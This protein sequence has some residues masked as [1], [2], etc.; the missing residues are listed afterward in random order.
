MAIR[1]EYGQVADYAALGVMAGEATAA[2]EAVARQEARDRQVMAIEAQAATQAR[3]QAH[4]KEMAEFGVYMDNIRYQSAEAWELEKMELRSRHDFDMV[5]A[6]REMDFTN[7]MQREQRQQQEQDAKLKAIDET[8][9][10][11]V[12]EKKAA[13][14]KI[15]T[16][17]SLPR[18]EKVSPLESFL[19]EPTRTGRQITPPIK[20]EIAQTRESQTEVMSNFLRTSMPRLD[21]AS[22][23]Q[24]KDIIA[25]GNPTEIKAAYDKIRETV[26][27]ETIRAE[28][29]QRVPPYREYQWRGLGKGLRY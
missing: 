28:Q 5:E 25:R 19:R 29:A 11:S 21:E 4:Q 26:A 18:A 1:V 17:A 8:D 16:G 9:W 13:K 10:L 14:F 15:M 27:P 23:N 20:S 24:L 6:R 22:Q 7:Q 3:T 12:D 2:R